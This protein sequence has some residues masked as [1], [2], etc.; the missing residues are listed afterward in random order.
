MF[1]NQFSFFID[2][3]TFWFD[4][5]KYT[6]SA[7]SQLQQAFFNLQPSSYTLQ[8]IIAYQFLH[9]TYSSVFSL[10]GS[11]IFKPDV[12]QVLSESL[13]LEKLKR[14]SLMVLVI[15]NYPLLLCFSS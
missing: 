7:M 13:F 1:V 5:N 3:E 14:N 10:D 4:I 8:N 11:H 9:N 15:Q 12:L 2:K 6:T